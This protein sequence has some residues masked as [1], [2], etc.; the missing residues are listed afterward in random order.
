ME[1]KFRIKRKTKTTQDV[2]IEPLW[3]WN[4]KELKPVKDDISL[5]RTFM[6]LKWRYKVCKLQHE[7]S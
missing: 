7:E 4:S 6:E 1:L 5:N 2:L 3:N